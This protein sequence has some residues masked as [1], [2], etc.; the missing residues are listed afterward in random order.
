MITKDVLASQIGNYLRHRITRAAL[1]EW[2]ELA[3]ME[4]Q[5][6]ERDLAAIRDVTARLG[7]ADVREFGLSWEDCEN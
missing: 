6:D 1:V 7:L 2:A 3:M 5:F 4:E